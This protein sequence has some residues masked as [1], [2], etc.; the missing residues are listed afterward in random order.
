[1]VI[2]RSTLQDWRAW[3]RVVYCALVVLASARAGAAQGTESCESRAARP[4]VGVGLALTGM[5]VRLSGQVSPPTDDAEFLVQRG[6][7]A[8]LSGELPVTRGYGVRVEVD[9]MALSIN[10]MPFSGNTG[11]SAAAADLGR[12]HSSQLLVGVVRHSVEGRRFCV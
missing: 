12:V 11:G 3:R 9:R 7:G 8:S 2:R 4:S 5:N 6:G 1:M 10:R